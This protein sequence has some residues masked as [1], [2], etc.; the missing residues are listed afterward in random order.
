[1]EIIYIQHNPHLSRE[2]FNY[3][4]KAIGPC[5][6]QKKPKTISQDINS[7]LI[8][9]KVLFMSI[10][11]IIF[12]CRAKAND[13]LLELIKIKIAKLF[14]LLEYWKRQVLL[15]QC[16]FPEKVY[17]K[18]PQLFFKLP[19]KLFF[20]FITACDT[21]IRYVAF[22]NDFISPF[23]LCLS[24]SNYRCVVVSVWVSKLEKLSCILISN[25]KI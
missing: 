22:H 21:F 18:A 23:D 19:L 15:Q 10:Y 6:C 1:M 4:I 3:G 5:T 8:T 16:V 11:F 14:G 17:F 12:V 7:L 13:E 2:D 24:H 9:E 25:G 20:H